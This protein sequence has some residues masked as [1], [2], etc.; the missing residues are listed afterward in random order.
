MLKKLISKIKGSSSSEETTEITLLI[1]G[2]PSSGKTALIYFLYC[3]ATDHLSGRRK[4]TQTTSKEQKEST[5]KESKADEKNTD[6]IN[7]S[8]ETVQIKEIELAAFVNQMLYGIATSKDFIGTEAGRIDYINYDTGLVTLKIF[9]I[10][11]EIFNNTNDHGGKIESLANHLESS[12][13][14]NVH[15]LLVDEVK[16]GT[17]DNYKINMPGVKAYFATKHLTNTIQIFDNVN[18]GINTLRVVTKFDKVYVPEKLDDSLDE[19]AKEHI[20]YRKAL[21]ALKSNTPINHLEHHKISY[22]TPS[23]DFYEG[24]KNAKYCKAFLCTGIYDKFTFKADLYEK[25]E[26]SKKEVLKKKYYENNGLNLIKMYGITEIFAYI[27]HKYE[28][29]K[30]I[31]IIQSLNGSTDFDDAVRENDYKK[32]LS[33]K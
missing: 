1:I 29:G 26:V 8:K 23:P 22:N 2:P 5:P 9:N 19:K 13:I 33:I 11:G 17:D 27:L 15:C 28:V 21:Y 4:K 6:A 31:Q 16:S 30:Q 7:S 20:I 24:S 12:N 25:D 32:I 3:F 14:E 18:K 10:S